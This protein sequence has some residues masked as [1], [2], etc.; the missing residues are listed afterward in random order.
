MK[1]FCNQRLWLPLKATVCSHH[2]EAF[3]RTIWSVLA[4]PRKQ[5]ESKAVWS[6]AQGH[7]VLDTRRPAHSQVLPAHV[8]PLHAKSPQHML[9]CTPCDQNRFFSLT[10]LLSDR[11]HGSVILRE[12]GSEPQQASPQITREE[13]NMQRKKK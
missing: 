9:L 5:D 11:T 10:E 6:P 3:W 2:S 13:R 4:N 12:T 8:H 7:S 1:Q